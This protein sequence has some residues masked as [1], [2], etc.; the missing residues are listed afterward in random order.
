MYVVW[1]KNPSLNFYAESDRGLSQLKDADHQASVQRQRGLS[2]R[3]RGDA[4]ID[5]KFT[6]LFGLY[7]SAENLQH[8][9]N[10]VSGCKAVCDHQDYAGG[11]WHGRRCRR[12]L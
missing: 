3:R 8:I 6:Q 1:P 4:D 11:S 12:F 10:I 5:I 7:T 9:S 2:C